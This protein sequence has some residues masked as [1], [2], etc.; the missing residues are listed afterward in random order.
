MA[1]WS[2]YKETL[3]YSKIEDEVR[4][5]GELLQK[6]GYVVP[7]GNV[8][9]MPLDFFKGGYVTGIQELDRPTKLALQA[10]LFELIFMGMFKH[11]VNSRYKDKGK[12]CAIKLDYCNGD[13]V[14]VTEGLDVALRGL[15]V[16]VIGFVFEFHDK[17]LG[18]RTFYFVED[19]NLSN[20]EYGLIDTYLDSKYFS[21]DFI[22]NIVLGFDFNCLNE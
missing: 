12:L 14:E 19:D 2:E 4:P 1:K 18:C 10:E 17:S 6:M 21:R 16:N 9:L 3:G 15:A 20:Y 22:N 8:E 11:I 5:L 13:V 7:H